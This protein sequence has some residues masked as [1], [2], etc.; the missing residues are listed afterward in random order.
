MSTINPPSVPGIHTGPD[1]TVHNAKNRF[2][3]R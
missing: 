3:L 2:D 1:L